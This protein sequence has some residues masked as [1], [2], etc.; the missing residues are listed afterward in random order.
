VRGPWSYFP[1]IVLVLAPYAGSCGAAVEP[2]G[3]VLSP[4]GATTS[5]NG[6]WRSAPHRGIDIRGD[7]G[8]KV[9]ASASGRV[10]QVFFTRR[11][12]WRVVLAHDGSGTCKAADAGTRYTTYSHLASLTVA[13]GD[14]LSRGQAM[15][16]IGRFSANA[17]RPHVHFGVC[18]SSKCLFSE[19]I[20]DFVDPLPHIS[21]CYDPRR[22]YSSAEFELT[23]PV[24]CESELPG[25]T[26]ST[27]TDLTQSKLC[28]A[29]LVDRPREP[30]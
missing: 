16:V 24:A 11:A 7:R 20:R 21:G 28:R 14:C 18:A 26:G 12:G 5:S 13:L 22:T 29:S 15:G 10:V 6:W 9:L 17:S 19:S 3:I 8:Q 27:E 25:A 23:Y 1:A 2:R 4:F 30:E